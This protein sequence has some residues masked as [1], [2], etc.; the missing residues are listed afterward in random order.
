MTTSVPGGQKQIRRE[1]TRAAISDSLS[2]LASFIRRRCE[3][4][5]KG[6]DS[7]K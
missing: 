1:Y 4:S 5:S 2:L 6:I 7:K 3:I